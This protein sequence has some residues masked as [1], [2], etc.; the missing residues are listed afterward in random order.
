M[1][2]PVDFSFNKPDDNRDAFMLHGHLAKEGYDWWW[3]SFTAHHET[4]G[5]ERAFFIEFFTINPEL[6]GDEPVFGQLPA[7]KAAGKK[8]SYLMVKAGSWGKD[9]AQLHRFFGW[10]D[11]T[12]KEEPP[13]LIS[14][15]ECFLSESR[16]L[17]KVE[18]SPEEAAAHP[19]YMCE[20]GRMI[21]DL[22]I[23]KQ[24]SF[25]VGYGASKALR[26]VDAFEMFWHVQGMKTAYEGNVVWNGENYIVRPEDSYGYADKNWGRD[27][28]SP[29]VWLTS[30]NIKS[31]IT[32]KQLKDTA[33]DIGGG[34][35]K[36]GPVALER[37]L[38]SAVWYE[39]T[40]YEFNFSKFW[41]LTRT[42]FRCKE[43]KNR[44]T[45]EVIQETP[46]TKMHTK[47]VCD[48]SDMLRVNYEAPD[49]SRKH[50]N[51]WNGGNGRG[52]MKLYKK[53]IS[54]KN[55]WKWELI[56]DMEF[57]NVG[58][59]YG[60]FAGENDRKKEGIK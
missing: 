57:Y 29:W 55:K 17:G 37:K 51:L 21:W 60:E 10:N 7:N 23:D 49:G 30:N 32:G 16:T 25:N 19:E 13:I 24:I 46:V 54:L 56:D 12:I 34:R 6:G 41:T 40:P 11:V 2:L 45:W 18:V 26:E 33:F 28:T 3:H 53:K 4:T 42:R 38:L 20:S 39:G 14:A 36:V 5:E 35:P 59:E 50:R 31:R 52:R 47:I 1:E 27:F 48:K 44:I 22:K 15:G 58:C 9:A 43:G 8:P